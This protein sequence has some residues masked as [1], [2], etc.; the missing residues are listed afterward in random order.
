LS[1]VP[2]RD[3]GHP[4]TLPVSAQHDGNA[5][6]A[7]LYAAEDE[8]GDWL[9]GGEALSA[10]WLT[11]TE[12]NVAVL[13]LSAAAEELTTRQTLRRLIAGLGYPLI[14]LRI[15]IADP[16]T[17]PPPDTPRLQQTQTIEVIDE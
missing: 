6:Y 16:D 3:F 14:A 1:T 5:G 10:V 4:G 9:R 17:P 15:G 11:A 12:H 13:P 2:A 8:P 7:I